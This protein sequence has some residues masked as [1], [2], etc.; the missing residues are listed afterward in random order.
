MGLIG[1]VAT[2][3]DDAKEHVD[4]ELVEEAAAGMDD[5]KEHEIGAL[6]H[7]A[8]SVTKG[9]LSVWLLEVLCVLKRPTQETAVSSSNEAIDSFIFIK[10][11]F[12]LFNKLD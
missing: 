11:N 12:I 7:E 10:D 3:T 1:E 9:K 5:V 6:Q 2:D 8:V 4:T